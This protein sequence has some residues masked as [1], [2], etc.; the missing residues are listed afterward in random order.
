MLVASSRAYRYSKEY[1]HLHYY[2]YSY[3]YYFE[4]YFS[5]YITSRRFHKEVKGNVIKKNYVIQEFQDYLV[6]IKSAADEA[7]CVGRYSVATHRAELLG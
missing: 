7:R 1:Q 2:V 4:V 6:V 3:I 5:E